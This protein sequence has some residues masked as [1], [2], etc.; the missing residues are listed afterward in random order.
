MFLVISVISEH[1]HLHNINTQTLVT[2]TLQSIH[3]TSADI[4]Y[5]SSTLTS[6]ANNTSCCRH[7]LT[8]LSLRW[9]YASISPSSKSTH[10]SIIWVHCIILKIDLLHNFSVIWKGPHYKLSE[11]SL[12]FLYFKTANPLVLFS[13]KWLNFYHSHQPLLTLVSTTCWQGRLNKLTL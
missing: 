9:L 8:G 4:S 11:F 6:G 13:Q 5:M 12:S 7:I 3:D 2:M 10:N 1:L